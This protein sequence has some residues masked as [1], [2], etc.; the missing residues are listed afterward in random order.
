M[1]SLSKNISYSILFGIVM[2]FQIN[3]ILQHSIPKMLGVIVLY[4]LLGI[5]TY[6]TFPAIIRRFSSSKIGFWA[7][8]LTHALVGLFVIEWYFMGNTFSHISD[9][10]LS[11]ISQLGMFAWWATIATMPY[12]LQHPLGQSLKIKILLYYGVYAVS[13]TTLAYIYGMAPIILMEPP[14]YLGFFYF[15][16]KFASLL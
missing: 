8:L 16:R 4:T 15:Y 6:Y 9:I 11:I 12:L 13:S 10:T 7:A 1:K 14:F 3:I 2:E 5:A